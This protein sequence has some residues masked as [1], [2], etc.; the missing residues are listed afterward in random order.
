MNAYHLSSAEI[1]G[2]KLLQKAF[3]KYYRRLCSW[4]GKDAVFLFGGATHPT[5][6]SIPAY[7]FGYVKVGSLR[8]KRTAVV[9]E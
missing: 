5:H 2:L 4:S 9:N 3:I 8:C 7:G 6:H 1:A